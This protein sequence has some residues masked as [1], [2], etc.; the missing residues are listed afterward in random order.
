MKKRFLLLLCA[1]LA[2]PM[3][4]SAE[5]VLTLSGAALNAAQTIAADDSLI[6]TE[7]ITD[8]EGTSGHRAV[9]PLKRPSSGGLYPAG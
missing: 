8:E 6:I 7:T 9:P 3:F 4:A 5:D 1:L 2:L